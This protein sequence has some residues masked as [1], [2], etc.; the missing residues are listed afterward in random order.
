MKKV[1]IGVGIGCGVLVLAAIV[2]VGAGAFWAKKT[3]GG[4]VE[5]GQQ[6]EAQ[7][8][9][10][11]QL[12]K[13]YPF[14]APPEGQVL[15]LQESRLNDYFAIREATLP[16]FKEFEAK[17]KAFE[18]KTQGNQASLSDAMQAGSMLAEFMAKTRGAYIE[19]LKKHKM[20]PNEFLAI[21][22]AIYSSHVA[23][24]MGE[25]NK[26]LAGQRE[27]LEKA[28]AEL[29]EKL[30]SDSLSEEERTALQEQADGLQAQLDAIDAQGDSA[31]GAP[32]V[33]EK[34]QGVAAANVKLLEK[35]KTRVE[36]AYNPG[37]DALIITD[38]TQNP[39]GAIG[40]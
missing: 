5:A 13:D 11:K 1:L 31:A 6:M 9:D 8:K 38:D 21:S 20:S 14:T 35:Y 33:D 39:Y 15:T 29:N 19:N 28:H 30:Q 22:G 3:L 16:V 27:S 26:A 7:Q 24:S 17:G 2:V 34:A 25:V 23:H 32:Q 36:Q 4:A 40:Q 12:N 10:L 37:F 18:A